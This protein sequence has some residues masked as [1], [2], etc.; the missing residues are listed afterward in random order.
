MEAYLLAGLFAAAV[1]GAPLA[2]QAASRAAYD[3]ALRVQ[4]EQL[5]TRHPVQ[6]VLTQPAGRTVDGY[7]LS[8]DVPTSASWKSV[9][10]KPGSGE[11]FAPAGLPKGAPVTVWTDSSGDLVSPPITDAQVAGQGDAGAV[12]AVAA[13]VVMFF[14]GTG[15]IRYVLHRRRIA[16]WEAD[17][18]L[19]A[20]MWNRQS[21]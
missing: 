13:V 6:A 21:W 5:A 17:W 12:G 15:V 9:T 18:L 20:P 2:A 14:S 10:G 16:A 8:G 1:A 3:G 7:M 4:K 19:T 11:V